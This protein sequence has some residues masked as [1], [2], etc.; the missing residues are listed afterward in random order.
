MKG[1][2]AKL[3]TIQGTSG[4]NSAL[5]HRKDGSWTGHP[6]KTKAGE[7]TAKIAGW[8]QGKKKKHVEKRIDKKLE[9]PKKVEMKTTKDS[10][11]VKFATVKAPGTNLSV[12]KETYKVPKGQQGAN[13]PIAGAYK[14]TLTANTS[15]KFARGGGDPYQYRSKDKGQS[16]QYKKIGESKWSDVKGGFE[17][18]STDYQKYYPEQ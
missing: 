10:G 5:K 6:H 3:G 8:F 17:D 1:S 16:F 4:H 7:M 13:K 14:N 11:D 15:Q 2:P 18:I 9:N 12:R